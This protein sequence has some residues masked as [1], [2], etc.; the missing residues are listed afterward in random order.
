MLK[1]Q[2]SGAE[3]NPPKNHKKERENYNDE[4]NTVQ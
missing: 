4:E 1:K 2:V 3:K